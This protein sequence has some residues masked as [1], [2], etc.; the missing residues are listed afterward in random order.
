MGGD[1]GELFEAFVR[2]FEFAL[3][4]DAL[5]HI[6]CGDDERPHGSVVV[7][8]RTDRAFDSHH[9]S[10]G[11]GMLGF[12]FDVFAVASPVDPSPEVGL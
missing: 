4:L 5:G 7:G 3:A 12:V 8:H 11:K 9:P 10:T 2:L 6:T 1:V